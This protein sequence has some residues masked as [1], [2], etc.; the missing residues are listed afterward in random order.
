MSRPF[1]HPRHYP[2]CPQPQDWDTTIADLATSMKLWWRLKSGSVSAT[3][4]GVYYGDAFS[5]SSSG[6]FS[7]DVEPYQR[8]CHDE[9]TYPVHQINYAATPFEKQGEGKYLS[10]ICDVSS[11]DLPREYE[12]SPDFFGECFCGSSS[13]FS[14]TRQNVTLANFTTNGGLAVPLIFVFNWES[15]IPGVVSNVA[16][17]NVSGTVT[18]WDID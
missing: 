9:D 12:A 3:I 17:S 8:V 14:Y 2:F 18:L 13:D 11:P 1:I 5:V 6:T 15:D 7:N 16:L 10:F 4:S